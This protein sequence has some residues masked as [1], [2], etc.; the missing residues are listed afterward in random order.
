MFAPL[1]R[2][3]SAVLFHEDGMDIN[4]TAPFKPLATAIKIYL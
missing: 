2:K 4:I 1:K 3:K